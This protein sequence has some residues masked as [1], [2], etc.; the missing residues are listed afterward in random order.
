[1]RQILKNFYINH[2]TT[3]TTTFNFNLI[4]Q[5][6]DFFITKSIFIISLT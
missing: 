5:I 1:M 2:C 3:K 4:I 6:T